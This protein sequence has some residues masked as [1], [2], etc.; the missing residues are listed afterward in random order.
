MK[1]L[2]TTPQGNTILDSD[3]FAVR[4]LVFTE[5][6]GEINLPIDSVLKLV[7]IFETIA[8]KNIHLYNSNGEKV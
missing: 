7:D 6:N 3:V 2:H 5:T 1:I 4:I 8:E